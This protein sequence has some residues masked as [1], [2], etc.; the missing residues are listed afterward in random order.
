MNAENINKL[1]LLSGIS[2]DVYHTIESLE[3]IGLT[4]DDT[5]GVGKN[6]YSALTTTENMILDEIHVAHDNETVTDEFANIRKV[7]MYLTKDAFVSKY[8][9]VCNKYYQN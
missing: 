6:L 3:S 5:T 9:D 8:L 2:Y 7:I 4:M 1:K